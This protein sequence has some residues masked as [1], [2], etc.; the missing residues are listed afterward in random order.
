M[1]KLIG[2]RVNWLWRRNGKDL[3]IGDPVDLTP[4]EVETYRPR[5]LVTPIESEVD[6][7]TDD[8]DDDVLLGS[9]TFPAVIKVGEEKQVS[10]GEVVVEAHTRSGLSVKEWNALTDDDID[11]RLQAVVDEWCND[12]MP[13]TDEQR[14]FQD[15]MRTICAAIAK[16]NPKKQKFWTKDGQ[17]DLVALRK[18][19]GD[20][21]ITDAER[22]AA[23]EIFKAEQAKHAG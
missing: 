3:N 21:G 7:T 17:P 1:S 8:D 20:I 18:A 16:L 13:L 14:K 12:Y 10:L 15:R 5:G 6:D 4:E 22:D 9:N 23:W 11:A 19:A 2:C